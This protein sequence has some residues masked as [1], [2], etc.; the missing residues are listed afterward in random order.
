MPDDSEL[1]F[2]GYSAF[3]STK[4]N[5]LRIPDYLNNKNSDNFLLGMSSLDSIEILPFN[6]HYT[7]LDNGILLYRENSE[8]IVYDSLIYADKKVENITILPHIKEIGSSS[9]QECSVKNIEFAED[10]QCEKIG[11]HAFKS[12]QIE[13]IIIPAQVKIIESYA[14]YNCK[15]LQSVDFPED[16]KLSSISDNAFCGTSI[17]KISFPSKVQ[18]IG[19]QSFSGCKQL[20][21]IVF[22]EQ[23]ELISICNCAFVSS[24][25]NKIVIPSKVKQICG[26]AFSCCAYLE[27]VEFLDNSECCIIGNYAFQ[28]SGIVK[29][30]IP[31][32]VQRIESNVF[33]DCSF[34]KSFEFSDQSE[35]NY[36]GSS[37]FNSTSIEKFKIPSKVQQIESN[38]FQN[39]NSL[40][41]IEFYENSE[42]KFIKN[43]AFASCSIEYIMI[44][45]SVCEIGD[46][47]FEGCVKL[48]TIEFKE[49]SKLRTIGNNVFKN[50][51]IETI[52][53]PPKV[54]DIKENCFKNNQH[55]K[56]INISKD[57]KHYNYVN[58]CL[59]L[60]KNNAE[61]TEFSTLVFVRQDVEKVIL[62]RYIQKIEN[63]AFEGCNKLVYLEIL[64]ESKLNYINRYV[65][66]KIKLKEIVVPFKL[67]N[68]HTYMINYNE[69]T[70][71]AIIDDDIKIDEF[72]FIGLPNLSC[73]SFPYAKK[74]NIENG[75]QN[76]IIL[77]GFDV[78]F[79]GD[80]N[81]LQIR[82]V[83][84]ELLE[85][86][87]FP[88][89]KE[90]LKFYHEKKT[91]IKVNELE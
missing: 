40:K 60:Y 25:I 4:I 35:L 73:V 20:Q 89:E 12:S 75:C 42:L 22:S 82:E 30:K 81:N 13:K 85:I 19:V 3:C 24:T 54:D 17:K 6:K 64:K 1:N 23:S 27:S 74:I 8:N 11:Q 79:I 31:D 26:S 53:I 41:S 7:Y 67:I 62:P 50:T 51:Q 10:S 56:T 65:L 69:I 14:F 77:C 58:D 72:T 91:L 49:D 36:I 28:S 2:I 37:A 39:C 84:D 88:S 32:S 68:I 34:F 45:S 33:K 9:F 15:K 59:L 47:A 55:L 71:I 5:K 46:N 86:N 76:L 16:S 44:P 29:I 48:K 90:E 43:N 70:K 57:N 80:K 61:N 18:I 38:T 63:N 83:D 66:S 87:K 78:K 52:S 21:S